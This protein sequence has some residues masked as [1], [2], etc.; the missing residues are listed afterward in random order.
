VT[1]PVLRGG[2]RCYTRLPA[3]RGFMSKLGPH[4]EQVVREL[5]RDWL[6][7]GPAV[8]FLEGFPGTGK[9]NEVIPEVARRVD[10][11]GLRV[12]H[13]TA[14]PDLS[15]ALLVLAQEFADVGDKSLAEAVDRGMEAAPTLLQT[16][17]GPVLIVLD[18]FQV[19]MDPTTGR[20]LGPYVAF[21]DRLARQHGTRGRLLLVTNR[22]PERGSWSEGHRFVTLPPFGDE[23]GVGLLDSLLQGAG[24]S[25]EV[26]S[27]RRRDIVRWCGGNPRA[28]RLVVAALK[29]S[30]LDELVGLAPEVWELRDREVDAGLLRRLETELIAKVRAGLSQPGRR[31]LGELAVFRKPFK[32]DAIGRDG[33][34]SAPEGAKEELSSLFLLSHTRGWHSLNPVAVE[35]E[36]ALLR[37]DAPELRRVHALA[38]AHYTRHFTAGQMVGG[39]RLGGH[40]VEARYH[41]VQAAQTEELASIA[42]RFEQ[43][44]RGT[45]DRLPRPPS[46]PVEL[47]ERIA[48]LAG[49]LDDGGAKG[50]EHHLA[51]CLE[52]RGAPGDLE[53]AIVHVRRVLGPR[54]PVETWVLG[55]RL[56]EK[57]G[58]RGEAIELARRGVLQVPAEK[59]LFALYQL[60]AELLGREGKPT[61]AVALLREGI[62]VI[63]ADK[64]LF[65]LYQSAAELLGH[66]GKPTEA[67][68]LLREGIKVIPAEKNLFALYQSA[69]ELL[70]RAGKPT[71]AVALLREGIK[72]IPADKGLFALYQIAAEL[73]GR[74]GKLSEAV[75]LLREGIKV[76]PADK[77]LVSL[78]QLAA[79]LLGRDGKLSEA[80]ALLREGIKVIPAD[81]NLFSLYQSAADL[82][83][84]DGKPTEAVALLREG[85][86]VIPADK[87]LFSLYQLATQML[88]RMGRL[89]EVVDLRRDAHR[90]IPLGVATRE[91]VDEA[92]GYSLLCARDTGRL[93]EALRMEGVEALD[94]PQKSLF[95]SFSCQIEGR[96]VEAAA[97]AREAR[98][99]FKNYL[100]SF[101]QEA[102]SL[103]CAG[104]PVKA[105]EVLDSFPGGIREEPG[106]PTFWLKALLLL[107]AGAAPDEAAAAWRVYLADP[108]APAPTLDDLLAAWA[109][110]MPLSTPHPAYYWPILPPSVTGYEHDL[111]RPLDG[112]GVELPPRV[113]GSAAP[114]VKAADDA[115]PALLFSWLHLSDIHFGHGDAQHRW[116]QKL[117]VE[118]VLADLRKHGSFGIPKPD[119]VLV[120]GDVAFS[121]GGREISGSAETEYGA[122]RSWLQEVVAATG[123]QPADV[124]LVPGNHD[125]NRKGDRDRDTERLVEALRE[126]H[127]P[128][129]T[130][131]DSLEYARDKALLC[132]RQQKYLEFA[133]DFAPECGAFH[134]SACRTWGGL[135]VRF[136][137]LNTALLA[138]DEAD[139]GKLRV[140]KE[141]L[142]HLLPARSSDALVVVLGHHPLQGGWLADEKEVLGWV[143]RH[144]AVYLSGHVHDSATEQS[145]SGSGAELVSVAAG[146]VHGEAHAPSVAIGHGYSV[147]AVYRDARGALFLRVWPRA[148][149]SK[150]KE[151][152][153]D[154][155]GV[156]EG[157]SYAEHP[158]ARRSR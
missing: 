80:V 73:L 13:V 152:R 100:T 26:P 115:D 33:A 93:A 105:L 91:R 120:T 39:G 122:A 10:G 106:N 153:S 24:R 57:A 86:K 149:S 114:V 52:A 6:P 54:A 50:L 14:T 65:S 116:D 55:V 8:C 48:V 129:Q 61:E 69:A 28:L 18:E 29:G 143:K 67:V 107:A 23:D 11:R 111:V 113:R 30:P 101:A 148:W 158:I 110:P 82:L 132:A 64:G 21:L 58:R 77:S 66:A 154:G 68:A 85:I 90:R 104:S 7:E 87:S 95:A 135:A 9:S 70:G 49:L 109:R 141:Q 97:H 150:N 96:W 17:R 98:A 103:L 37:E 25:A 40:F 74:D 2:R 38:A 121:G 92:V 4:Q 102:F 139:R 88:G 51:R 157:R 75:A 19:A 155:E 59:N 41:L 43:Y 45:I 108:T 119:V 71:E 27:E 99:R 130:L 83:G 147:G 32:A 12:V 22:S 5:V 142:A 126:R 44:V 89:A 81:K 156:P 124:F 136:V 31:L 145:R 1:E 127:A 117:V 56:C 53:R 118:Q 35:V 131:D 112:S 76:I 47:G 46:D 94:V 15:D 128:G 134:W 146:A 16:L 123:L 34:R 138:K 140:G 144:A 133:R 78:Y 62:K 79:E 60:A 125:V 42:G 20:P 36:R 3:G 63:P 84:R 72:V 151:F 137:G